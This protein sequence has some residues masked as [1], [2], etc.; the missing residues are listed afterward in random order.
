MSSDI[1][2]CLESK[3]GWRPPKKDLQASCPDDHSTLAIFQV[4]LCRLHCTVQATLREAEGRTGR[5]EAR[6]FGLFVI[7]PMGFSAC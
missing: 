1:K 6:A 5:F 3:A 2:K 7:F 4:R